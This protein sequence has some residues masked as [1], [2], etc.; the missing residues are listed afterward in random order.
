MKLRAWLYILAVQPRPPLA[1]VMTAFPL[2]ESTAVM[3]MLETRL[4]VEMS[5]GE[6][7]ERKGAELERIN[8]ELRLENRVSAKA[9]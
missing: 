8:D 3:Q 1:G 4:Q 9:H 6:V 2:L 5:R 7:F